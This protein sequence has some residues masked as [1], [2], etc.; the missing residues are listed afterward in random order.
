M[1]GWWTYEVCLERHV[2]QFHMDLETVRLEEPIVLGSFHPEDQ[3]DQDESQAL[4]PEL[5]LPNQPSPSESVPYIRQIYKGGSDCYLESEVS[6][7]S[8]CFLGTRV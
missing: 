6:T 1:Q 3:P 7:P 2:K 5:L 8:T 4:D